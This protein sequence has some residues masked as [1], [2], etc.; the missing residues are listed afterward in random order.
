MG[1]PVCVVKKMTTSSCV[2]AQFWGISD[3]YL[4]MF[5]EI[6]VSHLFCVF[7]LFF[8]LEYL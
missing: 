5:I 4:G 6:E 1:L 7:A 8:V 3:M 2:V